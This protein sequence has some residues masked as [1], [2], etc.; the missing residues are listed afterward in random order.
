[1]SDVHP[2]V[3]IF[4]LFMVWHVKRVIDLSIPFA[5]KLS[6]IIFSLIIMISIDYW[7][8]ARIKMDM[9]GVYT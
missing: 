2:F 9:D 5:G 1:M 6:L 7:E 3:V 4:N 8:Y